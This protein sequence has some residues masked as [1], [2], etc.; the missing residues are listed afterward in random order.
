[1]NGNGIAQFERLFGNLG[2]WY[3]LA[4]CL[5]SLMVHALLALMCGRWQSVRFGFASGP[6]YCHYL[7]AAC[8]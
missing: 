7:Y 4:F 3:W 2:L 1:M 5:S 6:L 8:C